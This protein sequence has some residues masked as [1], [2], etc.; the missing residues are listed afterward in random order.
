MHANIIGLD[1]LFAGAAEKS[2]GILGSLLLIIYVNACQFDLRTSITDAALHDGMV[3]S[4][5][6]LY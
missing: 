5:S 4:R 2:F 3:I 1:Q 6:N